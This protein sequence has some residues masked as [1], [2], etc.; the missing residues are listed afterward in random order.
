MK[1]NIVLLLLDI[2]N[3]GI[4]DFVS[5]ELLQPEQPLGLHPPDRG[6]LTSLQRTKIL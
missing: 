4:F 3:L 1:I 6:L 2:F 5:D